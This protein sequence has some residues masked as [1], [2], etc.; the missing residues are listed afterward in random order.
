MGRSKIQVVETEDNFNFSL[1]IKSVE[2]FYPKELEESLHKMSL[3]GEADP[4]NLSVSSAHFAPIY[5]SSP[6]PR[7]TLASYVAKSREV[8]GGVVTAGNHV[9]SE[10]EGVHDEGACEAGDASC[11]GSTLSAVSDASFH[12]FPSPAE[13][14]DAFAN[15]SYILNL[16]SDSDSESDIPEYEYHFCDPAAP[17]QLHGG[18]GPEELHEARPVRSHNDGGCASPIDG[19]W[20]SFLTNRP[21]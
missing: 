4:F 16:D 20:S 7:N 1:V 12:G 15:L 5:E 19:R 11:A 14:R 9:E 10:G 2:D 21:A 18:G 13:T 17:H 3:D 6:A 8:T